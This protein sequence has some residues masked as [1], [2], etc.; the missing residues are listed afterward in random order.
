MSASRIFITQPIAQSAIRRLQSLGEVDWNRD[1]VHIMT[2]DELAVAVRSHD[3]LYCLL[4]DRLGADVIEANP[5]LRII[6]TMKITP[7]DID[8]AAATAQRIPVTVI[9]PIVTEA[10]ADLHFALLL[11]VAR[12]VVEGDRLVRAGIFPGAQSVHLEGAGVYGKTIGLIGGGGRIGRAV[13]RRARG[14]AMRTLYWGPRRIPE[15]DERE[16]R[17]DYVPLD[18]L[19]ADSDFVSVHAP[20]KSETH[21]LVGARELKLMK[22]S[23]FLVNTARGPIVDEQALVEA[24]IER[25]IAGAALDVFEREP[26]VEQALLDMPNVVLTPHLGSA[27]AELRES[28]AHIVVDNIAAVL[29]GRRPPNCWNPEIYAAADNAN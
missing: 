4:P 6:A 2:K 1:P 20:L 28:M 10:T 3:I 19:L 15:P 29:E 9:P 7:S 22:P 14:F 11:A 21:H 25:R 23:A 27:V 13:A 12:R 18:G 26:Q 17:L 5:H 8:V 24:L 16:L